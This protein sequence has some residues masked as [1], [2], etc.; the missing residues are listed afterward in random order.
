MMLD[1]VVKRRAKKEDGAEPSK[2]IADSDG[3]LLSTHLHGSLLILCTL[4]LFRWLR[5]SPSTS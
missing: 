2:G 3:E 4:F 5:I 1:V